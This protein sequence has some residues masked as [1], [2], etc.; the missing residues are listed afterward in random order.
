VPRGRLLIREGN[1]AGGGASVDA[2]GPAGYGSTWTYSAAG[3]HYLVV[4]TNCGWTIRV[5]GHR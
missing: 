1:A 4:I 3:T 2:A 5:A